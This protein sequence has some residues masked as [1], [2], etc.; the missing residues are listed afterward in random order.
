MTYVPSV[1]FVIISTVVSGQTYVGGSIDWGNKVDFSPSTSGVASMPQYSLSLAL[2][3]QIDFRGTPLFLMPEV[4][5]GYIRYDIHFF[6]D[7][8]GR[9]VNQR[10][11][12]Y[13][14]YCS[15]GASVGGKI[16][17]GKKF[18][19]VGAGT[20]VS[21]YFFYE[22]GGGYGITKSQRVFYFD[23]QTS[24]RGFS[25]YASGFVRFPVFERCYLGFKYQRHFDPAVTGKYIFYQPD[26]NKEGAIQIVQQSLSLTVNVSL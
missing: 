24:A 11:G 6:N 21:Y 3:R 18:L 15:A 10:I 17:I 2:A 25:Y 7:H 9:L 4:N 12:D 23:F 5:A 16:P 8:F 13:Q 20:G 26:G 1:L 22:G 14:F 19:L